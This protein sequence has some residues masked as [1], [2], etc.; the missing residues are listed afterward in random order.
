MSIKIK[1]SCFKFIH[2]KTPH[3]GQKTKSRGQ[4]VWKKAEKLLIE[5]GILKQGGLM[6]DVIET[7][8]EKGRQ[9]GQKEV[10]LNMLKKRLDINLFQK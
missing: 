5:K 4:K 3:E 2:K 6:Q 9:E 8:E 7:I 1:N 10:I